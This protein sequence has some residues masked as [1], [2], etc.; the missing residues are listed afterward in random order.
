MSEGPLS[1]IPEPLA[2]PAGRG[3]RTWLITL[4]VIMG[5]QMVLIGCLGVAALGSWLSPFSMV[6]VFPDDN[7]YMAGETVAS[8]VGYLIQTA[9][10]DGYMALYAEDDD[11][12][13]RDAVR[14]EFEAVIESLGETGATVEYTADQIVLYEDTATGDR[15]ARI[16]CSG[17]DYETG[18]VR[19]KRLTVWVLYDEIPDIVLTSRDG[20]ELGRGE[21]LW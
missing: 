6:D 5:V 8:E 13:D 19:G 12:V 14:A 3:T 7:A 1:V 20:R 15:I 4:S 10:A 21:L 17:Y 16:A 2:T 18:R 9:D 11:T